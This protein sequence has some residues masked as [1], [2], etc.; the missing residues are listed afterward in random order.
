MNDIPFYRTTMGH[1]YYEHTLPQFARNVGRVADLL[2]RFVSQVEPTA[3]RS[4]AVVPPSK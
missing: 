4:H 3:S 1:R 2:E